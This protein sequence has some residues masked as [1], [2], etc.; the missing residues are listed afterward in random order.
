MRPAAVIFDMDGVLVDSE[1]L[2]HLAEI[3]AFADV[4]LSLTSTDCLQTTGLRVDAVVKHWYA[5]RPW[6]GPSLEHVA[7]D[8]VRR[9]EHL[10]RTRGTP[11]PGACAAVRFVADQ[12]IPVA[13][14]SSSASVLIDAVLDRLGLRDTFIVVRSAEHEP[15]GKPHPGVYLRTAADLGVAPGACLAVEDSANGILA[16]IAAGMRVVAVPDQPV[17]RDVLAQATVTLRSLED[18]PAR[19]PGLISP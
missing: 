5:R 7:V 12:G 11:L 1:P 13:L 8:I 16:A 9:V 15:Y 10:V 17:A 19:W 4:G 3:A 14:A 18:L 2:W 6:T